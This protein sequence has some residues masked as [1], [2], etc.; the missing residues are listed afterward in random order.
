MLAADYEAAW[1]P[2]QREAQANVAMWD[3]M[4]ESFRKNPLPSFDGNP[5]LMLLGANGMIAPN[6]R[7]LDVGCGTGNYALALAGRCD[8]IVGVDI[9]PRMIALAR[10]RAESENIGNAAFIC[11]DWAESDIAALGFEKAFDLSFAHMTPAIADA[12]SFRKLERT[13]KA[14]CAMAKPIRRVDPVSDEAKRLVGIV[15]RKESADSDVLKAFSIL[16]LDGKEPRIEYRRER[17]SM[18]KTMD[19]AR[20][21]YLNR[22]RTYRTLTED[23]EKALEGYLESI[24]E[25]GIVAE[26]VDTTIATLYWHT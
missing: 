1:R 8:E 20:G 9:S 19:E 25:D 23:E 10:S 26:D 12:A 24:A 7:V 5:F 18:R 6:A 17:W 21:L 3:S 13:S 11:L 2:K 4:A 22:I 16:Y 14:W 15:D